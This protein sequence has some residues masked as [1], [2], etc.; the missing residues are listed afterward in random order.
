M[1]GNIENK[2]AVILSAC[3]VSE[4]MRAYLRED[5]FVIACDAGYRNLEHLHCKPNLI[6]GD[7]DSAPNPNFPDTVVLPHVK[8]DTDTQYAAAW[9]AD[10]GAKQVLMLGAL[11]GKRLEHTIANLSTGLYLAKRGVNAVIANEQSEI[12]YFMPGKPLTLS[13][14]NWM[15][16]SVFPLEGKLSGVSIQGAYYPLEN[17]ALSMDYP[18]GVSNEFVQSEVQISCQ[19]GAGIAILTKA[20]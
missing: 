12:H 13:K 2:R 18:L 14:E 1:N 3:P 7:F 11:G 20:D 4:T 8:D 16:F 5:D 15:Y 17:A 10:H 9:A 19:G 6:V